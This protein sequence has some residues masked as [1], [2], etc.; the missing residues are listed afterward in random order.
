MNDRMK[1]RKSNAFTLIELLVV[2]AI[3]AL[4]LSIVMPGL[5]KAKEAAKNLVCRSNVRSLTLG[6]RMYTETNDQKGFVY[7]SIPD[8][9][10]WLLEMADQLDDVDKVRYCPNTKKTPDD[11]APYL[12]PNG[13]GSSKYTWAWPY[14]LGMANAPTATPS[15]AEFGSYA[16]NWWMY[17]DRTIQDSPLA[18]ETV[19]PPNS[20]N[21]PIFVDCKWVDF[22]PLNDHVAPADLNLD[23][24][25][26]G[27]SDR[28]MSDDV[29]LNATL[30]NRHQG[31][32]NV[33]FVD[34]H[35]ESVKLEELWSLKWGKEFRT[36]GAQT[37]DDGS[38]IY[39]RSR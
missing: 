17:S 37:R 24:G 13:M 4:L 21:V 29:S 30:L 22:I 27:G 36:L 18:W 5:R 10:L 16:T 32:T 23:L 9:N 2:I 34:G 14:H 12:W 25:G 11:K 3:I 39:Q 38:P 20:A 31:I 33:G 26:V 15:T 6:F 8:Q 28:I 35:A 19:N 7:T 1:T